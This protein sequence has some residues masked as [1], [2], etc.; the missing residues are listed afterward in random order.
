MVPP[1]SGEVTLEMKGVLPGAPSVVFAGFS[2]PDKLAKWSEPDGFTIQSLESIPESEPAT[3]SRCSQGGRSL[4][5]HRGVPKG[6]YKMLVGARM[7]LV[8]P[9]RFAAPG[10][11]RRTSAC[12]ARDSQAGVPRERSPLLKARGRERVTRTEASS[13]SLARWL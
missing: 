3:A 10:R 9:W 12:S 5:S 13:E 4:L 7:R 8:A 1:Q 6:G 2:D 11:R